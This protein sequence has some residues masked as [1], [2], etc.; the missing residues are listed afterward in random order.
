MDETTS[1]DPISLENGIAGINEFADDA[2]RYAKFKPKSLA[3]IHDLPPRSYMIKGL[4]A[5]GE[6][7][8]WYGEPGCTKSFLMM[9]TARSLAMN[10]AWFEYRVRGGPVVIVMA[11]GGSGAGQRIAAMRVAHGLADDTPIHIITVAPNLLSD[12]DREAII[13]WTKEVGAILIIMDTLSRTM[14]GDDSSS[15]DMP[16]YIRACDEIRLETRAHVAVIHHCGKDKSRG[17]RGHS[18][19][20]GAT[21]VEVYIKKQASGYTATVT[22][23][24]DGEDGWHIG[25]RLEVHEVGIDDD[26]DPITSCAVYPADVT[27]TKKQ[28]KLS[29]HAAR[30]LDALHE[31]LIRDGKVIN[32]R[33]GIPDGAVCATL[34]VLRAEF[35][36]RTPNSNDDEAIALASKERAFRRN[37][38][39]IGHRDG[40]VWNIKNVPGQDRT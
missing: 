31:I 2:E 40:I 9:E 34:E 7:S 37:L 1:T 3:E 8:V 27:P 17:S 28:K 20:F 14:V 30:L 12:G 5:P 21:D 6:L 24:K 23:N 39:H 13:Y 35:F 26:G 15:V 33:T 32:G 22:K 36:A 25:Y 29:N 38:Y 16:K 10:I 4:L 11:E 19:L 18:S